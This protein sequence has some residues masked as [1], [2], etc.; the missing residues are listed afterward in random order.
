MADG[1]QTPSSV[2]LPPEL[3]QTIAEAVGTALAKQA[4]PAVPDLVAPADKMSVIQAAET[5]GAA[6][7]PLA[8]PVLARAEN[9]LKSRKLWVT[10]GTIASLVAQN[11]LGLALP[12]AAQI[13]IA[14]VAGL[15]VAGQAL[16]DSAKAGGGHG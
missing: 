3:L 12:P 14:G 4:T 8:V 15:Y 11:P 7:A 5:V 16:V 6:L 9:R 2:E 10:I 1:A 13:A